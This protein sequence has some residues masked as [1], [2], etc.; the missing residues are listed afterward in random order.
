MLTPA[1]QLTMAA[2][3]Q[4]RTLISASRA[5]Q[6]RARSRSARLDAGKQESLGVGD[7]CRDGAPIITPNQLLK[8]RHDDS[9]A[10]VRVAAQR[11]LDLA[12]FHP[13]TAPFDLLVGPADELERAVGS[14]LARSPVAYSRW[15]GIDGSGTNRSAV[16]ADRRGSRARGPCQPAVAQSPV[17]TPRVGKPFPSTGGIWYCRRLREHGLITTI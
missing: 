2:I 5:F 15:P 7:Q 16:R 6:R 17:L 12:E 4:L 1:R 10:N 14:R 8:A 13:E 11:R 3:C 9:I